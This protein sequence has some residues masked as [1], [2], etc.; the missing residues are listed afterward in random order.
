MASK[1]TIYLSD[2]VEQV[3]GNPDSLSGRISSIVLRYGEIMRLECP[4]LSVNEW[5]MICDILNGTILDCDNRDADPARF[6]WAD[7]A[8]SG[9]LDGMAAKWEIDTESLSQRVRDMS[10]SQRCAIIEIVTRF[11]T[12]EHTG[13]YAELLGKIGAKIL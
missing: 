7:I 2:Q 13:E 10:H 9:Q 6:L 3:L 11:W 5:M 8:E 4:E 1:K 12:G